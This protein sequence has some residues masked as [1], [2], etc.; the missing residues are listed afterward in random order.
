MK[1]KSKTCAYT[2]RSTALTVVFL[3]AIVGFAS[4]FYLSAVLANAAACV[5]TRRNT[6]TSRGMAFTNGAFYS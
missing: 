4:A 3:L 5:S 1:T 2:I 6:A